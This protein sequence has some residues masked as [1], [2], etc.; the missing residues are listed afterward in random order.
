MPQNE[1]FEYLTLGP[2]LDL[3]DN[4]MINVNQKAMERGARFVE[5][6]A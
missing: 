6:G 2:A 1:I 3:R 5:N 4:K